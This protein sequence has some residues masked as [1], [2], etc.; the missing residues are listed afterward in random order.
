MDSR[1]VNEMTLVCPRDGRP[2]DGSKCFEPSSVMKALARLDQV[3]M[4][5]LKLVSP[6][7]NIIH[8]QSRFLKRD[9]YVCAWISVEGKGVEGPNNLQNIEY[10]PVLV[11]GAGRPTLSDG[12][13]NYL[14]IGILHVPPRSRRILIIS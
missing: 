1:I 2:T 9:V 5:N 7:G 10:F 12:E 3:V 6:S 8:Q 4:A 14:S 13:G 11:T